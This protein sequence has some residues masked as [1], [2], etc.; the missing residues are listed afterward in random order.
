MAATCDCIENSEAFKFPVTHIDG[1]ARLQIANQGSFIFSLLSLL[2]AYN[3]EILANSSLNV[4]GDPTC[5]DFID[6]LLVCTNTS[7]EY[8]LT[9]YGLLKKKY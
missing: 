4:S 6:G 9:D 5:F 8:L 3:I 2:S 7:L 1:T